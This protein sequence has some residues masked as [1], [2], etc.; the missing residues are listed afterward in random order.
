MP[1]CGMHSRPKLAEKARY[2][3]LLKIKYTTTTKLPRLSDNCSFVF[4]CALCQQAFEDGSCLAHIEFNYA[5]IAYHECDW[6]A[7][8]SHLENI[9]VIFIR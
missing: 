8:V 2:N 5:L 7:A 1:G 4:N 3:S 6:G 9:K